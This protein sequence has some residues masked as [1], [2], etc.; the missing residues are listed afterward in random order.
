MLG[1][2]SINIQAIR[3]QAIYLEDRSY[4]TLKLGKALAWE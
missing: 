2:A 1:K 3:F 4:K